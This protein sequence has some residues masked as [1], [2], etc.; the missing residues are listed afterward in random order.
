V[1]SNDSDAMKE[2]LDCSSTSS[3]DDD[4]DS[5]IIISSAAHHQNWDNKNSL[6]RLTL[7]V[8]C[9]VKTTGKT[10]V[11]MEAMVGASAAALCIYD[12]VRTHNIH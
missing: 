12:M 9:M 5:P 11:E 8:D 4:H 2:D 3:S 10:G 6:M 7:S 1:I